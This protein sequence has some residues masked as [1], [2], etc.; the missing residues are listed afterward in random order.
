M[1]VTI[2][3]AIKS[4]EGCYNYL[5]SLGEKAI[6]VNVETLE[7]TLEALREKAEREHPIPL[8]YE[9]MR[10]MHEEAVW[11]E[12]LDKKDPE[13]P[14]ESV[15]TQVWVWDTSISFFMFG[16]E[17]DLMPKPENYGKTWICYRHKPKEG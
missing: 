4:W 12:V 13:T 15:W 1:S 3:Q 8:T 17:C 14:S 11:F 16:N 6:P 5:I 10:Q 9:E 2:Q 7:I